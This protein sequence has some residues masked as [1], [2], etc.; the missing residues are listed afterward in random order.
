MRKLIDKYKISEKDIYIISKIESLKNNLG[1]IEK[2][3]LKAKNW[4]ILKGYK[5]SFVDYNGLINEIRLT[6]KYNDPK[7]RELYDDID[8]L[9]ISHSYGMKYALIGAIILV[10]FFVLLGG[11]EDG[12]GCSVP[13]IQ[14]P[15]YADSWED[16]KENWE[17][18]ECEIAESSLNAEKIHVYVFFNAKIDKY[19]CQLLYSWPGNDCRLSSKSYGM[20]AITTA[21]ITSEVYSKG[22]WKKYDY[23]IS[24]Q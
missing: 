22:E 15:S 4:T 19:R 12:C 8:I 20:N 23:W 5:V 21:D 11:S 16:K 2:E 18:K 17:F 14:I 10:F 6:N 7:M 9:S 13:S 1:F 3:K 24:R